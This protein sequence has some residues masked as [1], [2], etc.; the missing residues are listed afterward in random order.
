MARWPSFCLRD[1]MRDDSAGAALRRRRT[2]SRGLAGPA[3]CDRLPLS[4]LTA[5]L[6]PQIRYEGTVDVAARASATAGAP[7]SARCAANS[8]TPSSG[9]RRANGKEDL[10]VR[11]GSAW[12]PHGPCNARAIEAKLQLDAGATGRIDGRPL[13]QRS[14]DEFA[15]L[16]LR[17]DLNARTDA[18]GLLNLY[19]PELDRSAGQLDVDVAIGGTLGTPLVN[20]VVKLEDGELDLYNIN[21]ALRAATLEA[22]LIDNGFSFNGSARS[23]EGSLEANGKLTWRAG[24]P[25]GSLN[26]KR[27]GPTGGQR[28]GGA[29]NRLA[30]PRVQHR[31]S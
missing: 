4:T 17:A 19:I 27:Q 11:L 29:R 18:I 25:V 10:V 21:L 30:R 8:P 14:A 20:G 5:G 13:V 2:G 6:T 28:A 3:R 15:D 12:S 9:N 26:L 16:P 7:P 31:R 1:D 23:G 24:Q 22:R